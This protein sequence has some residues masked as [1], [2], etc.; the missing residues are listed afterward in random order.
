[1][2]FHALDR[3]LAVAAVSDGA[4]SIVQAEEQNSDYESGI[5]LI[6]KEWWR[7][8][9]ARITP[10][11]PGAFVALW[12][13]DE[14]G[15]TRSFTADEAMS[16]LLVFVEDEQRGSPMALNLKCATAPVKK[17]RLPP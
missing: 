8:R 4:L 3:F 15:A 14:G 17:G 9:T 6:G 16:G 7:I 5:A 13:R 10:T 1:M 12:T 11:K 2:T